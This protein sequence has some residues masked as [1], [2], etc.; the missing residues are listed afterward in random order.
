MA[1][2]VSRARKV[3]A[4]PVKPRNR[5][6]KTTKICLP[7][8]PKQGKK[9][10]D[11]GAFKKPM[12]R[13][14]KNPQTTTFLKAKAPVGFKT[15]MERKKKDAEKLT[16]GKIKKVLLGLKDPRGSTLLAIQGKLKRSGQ[17]FPMKEVR[18]VVE[19]AENQQKITHNVDERYRLCPK[20]STSGG[21]TSREVEE[22]QSAVS[23][24][25]GMSRTSKASGKRSRRASV[26][27]S[28]EDQSV[29]D[30]RGLGQGDQLMETE[31]NDEE[32]ESDTE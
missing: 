4:D 9:A 11:A 24:V 8:L 18:R 2:G 17:K 29:E 25:S 13:P 1:K 16:Y 32:Q 30:K 31:P 19:K 12:G 14:P 26:S 6:T 20:P 23:N 27:P 15:L 7:K 10:Q 5:L 21:S 3:A 28:E 22:S